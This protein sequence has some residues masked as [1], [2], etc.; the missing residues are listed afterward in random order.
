MHYSRMS[1][2]AVVRYKHNIVDN[3]H[4]LTNRKQ[5][6]IFGVTV[7]RFKWIPENMD[8]T[9]TLSRIQNILQKASWY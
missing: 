1:I 8:D 3:I 4:I 7:S 2:A 6:F 9:R 5:R